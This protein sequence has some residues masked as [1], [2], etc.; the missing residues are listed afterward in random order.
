MVPEWYDSGEQ[1]PMQL[2]ESEVGGYAASPTQLNKWPS[3]IH[4]VENELCRVNDIVGLDGLARASH[5]G[6]GQPT[7]TQMCLALPRRTSAALGKVCIYAHALLWLS[8]RLRE[9]ADISAK[10]SEGRSI[11]QGA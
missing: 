7:R 3:L 8:R 5:C 1:H 2:P 9:L 4:A 11:S 10:V 6:R